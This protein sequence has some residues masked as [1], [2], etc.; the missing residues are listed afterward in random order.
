M[1]LGVPGRVVSIA[2]NALGMMMGQVDFGGLTREVC[3]AFTPEVQAGDYVIVHAGYAISRLDEQEAQETLQA[4]A[5]LEE[6]AAS[7]GESL[8]L[9]MGG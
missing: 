1:C 7:E 4:L 5:E 3:L 6:K 8:S 2:E 9:H